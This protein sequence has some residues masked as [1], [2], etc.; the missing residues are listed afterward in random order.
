[1]ASGNSNSDIAL[2]ILGV[3]LMALGIVAFLAGVFLLSTGIILGAWNLF[4]APVFGLKTITLVQ[5]M[6]GALL[7]VLVNGLLRKIKS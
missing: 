4:V 2:T 6:G 1:M 5:A 7:L 3:I